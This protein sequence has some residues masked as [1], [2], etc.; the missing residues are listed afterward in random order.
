MVIGADASIIVGED[1]VTGQSVTS[2]ITTEQDLNA[3]VDTL[4]EQRISD[5]LWAGEVDRQQYTEIHELQ[6][7]HEAQQTQLNNLN[8]DLY[9]TN[10]LI[11]HVEDQANDLD[12]RLATLET[13]DNTGERGAQGIQGERGAKGDRGDRGIQGERGLTGAKGDQGDQGI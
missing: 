11:Y 12:S 1:P 6:D 2:A 9:N 4:N 3:A 10:A 7:D 13:T 8:S 5:L